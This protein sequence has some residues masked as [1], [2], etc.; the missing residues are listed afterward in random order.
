MAL[1]AERLVEVVE[2]RLLQEERLAYRVIHHREEALYRPVVMRDDLR[3][4]EL[5]VDTG[6]VH[7]IRLG[8]VE[9]L[10]IDHALRSVRVVQANHVAQDEPIVDG[11]ISLEVR[12]KDVHCLAR[13]ARVGVHIVAHEV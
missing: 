13:L 11:E 4:T 5:R 3:C 9:R 6:Y 2:H 1:L 10:E 8:N 7:D 12:L